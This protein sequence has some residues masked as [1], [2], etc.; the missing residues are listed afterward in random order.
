[1]HYSRL[2]VVLLRT[3][4]ALVVA[5]IGLAGFT[6]PASDPT[7]VQAQHFWRNPS[8]RTI[9]VA[10]AADQ[11]EPKGA[12]L[13]TNLV[14]GTMPAGAMQATVLTDSNCAPDANGISHCLNDLEIGG[15]RV[16]VQH[17]HDM[18]K[19]PC[20]APGEKVNIVDEATFK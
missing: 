3:G 5:L 18:R 19:V 15:T 1:M 14:A 9:V 20:L 8:L 17:H 16:T 10:P 6:Q 7:A 2:A 4:V 12:I 13:L 11:L